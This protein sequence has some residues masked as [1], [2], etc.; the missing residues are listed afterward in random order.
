VNRKRYAEALEEYRTASRQ[1]PTDD[2]AWYRWGRTW[3]R[4]G[5]A[6]AERG[7]YEAAV[8]RR[9]HCFKPR[10]WLASWAYR[11]GH[12]DEAVRGFEEMIRRA[13][14]FYN[15]Y[16]SLGGMLLLRGEYA[17]AVDTLRLAVELNPNATAYS[18]LGTAYFNSGQLAQAVDAYNQA[19][20]F[21][22]ADY[23]LWL[24]LGDAY[25]FLRNR[26]DQARDAYRQAVRVG[27]EEMATRERGGHSPDPMIFA[28]LAA[29]LPKLGEADSA[30]SMLRQALAIDSLNSRVQYQAA[31]TEWQL[32]SRAAAMEWLRRSVAGG[33]PVVWLRDSPV[34]RD[35]RS[36]PAFRALLASAAAAVDTRSPDKGGGR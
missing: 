36:E 32:G 21:D 35:W 34:H 27:H 6:E 29:A 26:P 10:W 15:G 25:Y 7:V 12:V 33:Y 3:Q 31:L 16:A 14:N 8:A 17:K 23:E 30:R 24:N 20:Q 5:D 19:F 18:N 28:H 13:P 9:P 4:A 22:D 2:E 11:N 1:D